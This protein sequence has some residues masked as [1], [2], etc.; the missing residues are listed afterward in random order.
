MTIHSTCP[1]CGAEF[2]ARFP[3]NGG[4]DIFECGTQHFV[5]SALETTPLCLARQEIAALK[6]Q[7]AE[8]SHTDCKSG[9]EFAELQHTKEVWKQRCE[10]YEKRNA[11]L[12]A[13]RDSLREGL[14][15]AEA[16]AEKAE[17]ERDYAMKAYAAE[18][19]DYAAAMTALEPTED[20]AL[21]QAAQRLKRERD[22]ARERVP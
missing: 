11:A 15:N 1:K 12:T 4:P 3:E 21:L 10:L 18:T 8:T 17:A 16:R 2:K 14:C 9:R 6:A 7:L 20:E 5:G 19:A 22:E 13:E